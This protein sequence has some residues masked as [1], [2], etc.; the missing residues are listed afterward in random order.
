METVNARFA[1]FQPNN[2]QGGEDCMGRAQAG[3]ADNKCWEVLPCLCEWPSQTTDVYLNE[4]GPALEARAAEAWRML[5]DDFR[6]GAA[7]R[8]ARGSAPAILFVLFMELYFVRWLQ[9]RERTGL[10]L[11][12]RGPGRQ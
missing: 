10:R 12:S 2:M 3:Y 11:K 4:H 1:P 5:E 6:I 9:R 7:W 8:A